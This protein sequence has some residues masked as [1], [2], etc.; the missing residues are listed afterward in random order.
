MG[1]GL[2]GGGGMSGGGAGR[3]SGSERPTAD[4]RAV[5]LIA[6]RAV[7]PA[8]PQRAP[9]VN[10]LAPHLISILTVGRAQQQA[11]QDRELSHVGGAWRAGWGRERVRGVRRR[12]LL[13][14]RREESTGSRSRPTARLCGFQGSPGALC[15]SSRGRIAPLPRPPPGGRPPDASRRRRRWPTSPHTLTLCCRRVQ[16]CA[17]RS[18]QQ[19]RNTESLSH[20]KRYVTVEFW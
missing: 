15:G 8:S 14:R 4:R 16:E 17:C 20:Q 1:N 11:A 5:C 9:A 10:H 13:G 2:G 19:G 18:E 7:L 12:G 6:A 3:A